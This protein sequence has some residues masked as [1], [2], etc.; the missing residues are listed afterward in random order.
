MRQI[1]RK[2]QSSL[3]S[4]IKLIEVLALLK[5]ETLPSTREVYANLVAD[6]ILSKKRMKAYFHLLP[7]HAYATT[8]NSNLDLKDYPICSMKHK[9]VSGE[10]APLNAEDIGL[11]LTEMLPVVSWYFYF[12]MNFSYSIVSNQIGF[13]QRL[14]VRLILQQHYL[15]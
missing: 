15:V 4:Y 2:F 8:D 6:G 10:L 3:L 14:H 9:D 12:R 7:G 13:N 11:A 5:P 1:Q